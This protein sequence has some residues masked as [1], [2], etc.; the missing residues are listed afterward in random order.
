MQVKPQPCLKPAHPTRAAAHMPAPTSWWRRRRLAPAP[1]AGWARA[2]APPRR[3]WPRPRWWPPGRRAPV[4]GGE[5]AW[6]NVKGSHGQP[7]MACQ[8]GYQPRQAVQ[9]EH[10]HSAAP[11]SAYPDGH[12]LEGAT[13]AAAAA[14]HAAGSRPP[15]ALAAPSRAASRRLGAAP[16]AS[17][18]RRRRVGSNSMNCTVSARYAT[19]R[20]LS[21]FQA[22]L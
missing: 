7:V 21:T 6:G 8:V 5:T 13:T 11:L 4:E 19:A 3:C 17:H 10:V 14:V 12:L 20:V 1:G 9:G 16:H 18:L 22:C 15:V 2:A